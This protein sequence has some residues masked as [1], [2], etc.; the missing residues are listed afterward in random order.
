VNQYN[1][2]GDMPFNKGQ[3]M[4]GGRLKWD[5]RVPDEFLSWTKSPLFAIVH[6][7]GRHE[8]GQRPV[9][10]TFG[11]A[12]SLTTPEASPA[13]FY[14]AIALHEAFQ[15]LSWN[16]KTQACKLLMKFFTHEILSHGELRDPSH[17][18]VHVTLEKLAENG[19]FKLVPSLQIKGLAERTRLYEACTAVRTTLFS[20]VAPRTVTREDLTL[21]VRLAELFK[22]AT[23]T[24]P[25]LHCLLGLLALNKKD[26][27][28]EIFRQHIRANYNG[29]LLFLSAR[30]NT[31]K[32]ASSTRRR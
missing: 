32:R 2:V 16:W 7:L 26:P 18:I 14:S 19:L 20:R 28:E 1:T 24:K 29:E 22:T 23:D 12:T 5:D 25:P 30:I 4:I 27:T 11:K 31:T 17:V 9:Y 10:V 21:C 6:A 13:P 15:V 8:Q 3:Q